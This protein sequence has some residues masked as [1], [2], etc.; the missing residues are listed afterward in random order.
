MP[1]LN[2]PLFCQWLDNTSV[3]NHNL[4]INIHY[5]FIV[6]LKKKKLKNQ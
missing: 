6:A 1:N 4:R 3:Y 5:T 2:N